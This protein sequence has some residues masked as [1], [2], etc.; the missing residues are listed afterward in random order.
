MKKLITVVLALVCVMGLMACSAREGEEKAGEVPQQIQFP[1]NNAT[2]QETN[3]LEEPP[4]LTVIYGENNSI[5]ALWGT[6]SWKYQ[7]EDGAWTGFEADSI[8][9]LAAKEYMPCLEL[10]P[11]I[12][13]S[14]SH[15]KVKM[16]WD[17][18]PDKTSVRCWNEKDW[19]QPDAES[20]ELQVR[21]LLLDSNIET[22]PITSVE[23]KDG[24][25]VYEVIAEWNSHEEYNGIARYSFYTVK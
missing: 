9:P 7:N 25:Y 13:S 23:L 15:L 14:G 1:E 8:H 2:S 11:V 6:T 22:E 24:N 17:A 20:E 4:A 5:E 12:T 21:T 19:G 3:V 10:L 16:Q 18:V